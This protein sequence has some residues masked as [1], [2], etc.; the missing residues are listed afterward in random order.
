MYKGNIGESLHY[1]AR[2]YLHFVLRYNMNNTI[3]RSVEIVVECVLF[4]NQDLKYNIITN[5]LQISHC[6]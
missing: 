6:S 4:C 1:G 5:G 2:G 3:Y